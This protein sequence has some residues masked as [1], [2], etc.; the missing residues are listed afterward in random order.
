MIKTKNFKFMAISLFI[1]MNLVISGL[2]FS[3]SKSNSL[4]SSDTTVDLQDYKDGIVYTNIT[5]VFSDAYI[6]DFQPIL[7]N[8]PNIYIPD[9]LLSRVN[10]TFDNVTAINYTR[11]IEEEFTEFIYASRL[12]PTY[13]FQKFSI[14]ISQFVNNVSI[15]I[16]DICDLTT[17][18]DDNSWEIALVNCSEDGI[19][20]NNE[21]LGVL[22][23]PHPQNFAAKWYSFDFLNSVNGAVFLNTSKTN[24]TI[25][26]NIIKYWFAIRIK[27]PP[28][29]TFNDGGPKF[30]YFNPD[31]APQT[32]KG[33][34]E[35]YAISPHFLKDIYFENNIAEA[36]VINGT[37]LNG[38]IDS[39]KTIDGDR[40]VATQDTDN[41]TIGVRFEI[42][43]LTKTPYSYAFWA[44]L[45]ETNPVWWSAIHHLVI[46]SLDVYLSINITNRA[47]IT[48]ASIWMQDS[49]NPSTWVNISSSIDVFPDNDS[50]FV[51]KIRDPVEKGNFLAFM[52]HS[53]NGNNSMIFRLD[54]FS[55][56]KPFNI[57]I[58]QATIEIAELE[59][60]NEVKVYDPEVQELYYPNNVSIENGTAAI[61][62]TTLLQLND[63]NFYFAQADTDNISAEFKLNVVPDLNS[64]L[65][66]MDIYEWMDLYPNPLIPQMQ[67][68]IS[69]NASITDPA[70]LSVA[71]LEVYKGNQS[72]S[73][74]GTA[75]NQLDWLPLSDINTF[76]EVGETTY[77]EI[78]PSNYTWIFMQLLNASD[79][80]SLTLRL[81]FV[82]NGGFS[83]F[84]ISID[85][86]S[87]TFFIKNAY[88]SDISVKIGMGLMESNLDVTHIN[89]RNFGADI[90]YN[91]PQT[92]LWLADISDGTPIQGFYEF[93]VTSI[94]PI[95]EF[96]VKGIYELYKLR[97]LLDFINIFEEQYS[98]GPNPFSVKA[99]Y[100]NGDP[101]TN[102][103]IKFE[104]LDTN[105][106][107]ISETTA[108]TNDQGIAI[109]SV[110]LT[111]TGYDFIIRAS[112][113]EKGILTSSTTNSV[114]FRVVNGWVTFMDYLIALLPYILLLLSILA[115]TGWVMHRKK[116]TLREIWAKDALILDDLLKISYILVL[117]KEIGVGLYSQQVSYDKLDPDLISGFLHAIS[118]FRRELKKGIEDESTTGKTMEMDYYD[119]KIVITDGDIIR[120][121]L[122]LDGKPSNELKE[123]QMKFTEHFER[124][125]NKYLKVD[126]FDGDVTRFKETYILVEE[127]FNISLM[128]PFQLGRGW[129]SEKVSEL[130]KSLLKVAEQME[131]EKNFFFISSLINYGIAGRREARDS[132]I[133]AVLTLKERGLIIS[134]DLN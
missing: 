67:I 50:L 61:Q 55:D 76:A 28:D 22:K 113:V 4:G 57:S 59:T 69:A 42:A 64:S 7:N 130:Q 93:N 94:W 109:A 45:A 39:F 117:H 81:R 49:N 102:I 3:F 97:P 74:L 88:S 8:Q 116:I 110:D 126:G 1:F 48:S 20:Y 47:N 133:S 9:Y 56:G 87:V 19:P 72:F 23:K 83:K 85:Q 89:L 92:G 44:I 36:L 37:V 71:I 134:K 70:N 51:V 10:M 12:G 96:D 104:V 62:S 52:N 33:E 107:I 132:I 13:V 99:L 106:R 40:Y 58:D 24:W 122:I 46:F 2:F 84:N 105:G 86:M 63:D 65:W 15:F 103:E 11:V 53:A 21:T 118:Q 31:D 112:F 95:I 90:A 79:Q 124:N 91:G 25:E 131:K 101:V 29:D 108:I 125:H 54:Y 41:L 128:Y 16:Q 60:I 120:V 14:E 114:S 98:E 32:N 18:N 127:Y 34:G 6:D 123:K 75:E 73:F 78:L 115:L 27:I 30:L 35:T 80:N 100:W 121:A 43:N 77:A 82:G 119:S 38:D 68:G 111:D 5:S 26:N 66:S 129:E 17:Y